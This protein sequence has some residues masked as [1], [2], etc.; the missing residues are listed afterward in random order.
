MPL[1]SGKKLGPYEIVSSIGAGGMDDV[2][3]QSSFAEEEIRNSLSVDG[4]DSLIDN[5]VL[6]VC[7]APSGMA[8]QGKNALV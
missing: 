2:Q 8:K 1:A 5:M 3:E 7:L 6:G 4:S